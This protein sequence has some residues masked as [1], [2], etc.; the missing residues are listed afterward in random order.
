MA[1]RKLLKNKKRIVIKVGSSTITHKETENLDYGKLEKLVRIITD[2]HNSGKDVVLVTSGAIAVGRHAIGLKDRPDTLSKKQACAAIGQANLM[3]I[4][5]KLFSEYSQLCAQVLL[6]RFT[7]DSDESYTNAE[8]TFNELFKLGV[9]PI[10]NEN[11]TISTAEIKIGDNDSLSAY[12]S[13]MIHADLLILMSDIDGL[14]SADPNKDK[15]AKFISEVEDLDNCT[16]NATDSASSVGTGGMQTKL[17]A[18]AI[19]TKCGA[20]MV[21]TN[22]NDVENIRR[23]LSGENTGTIFTAAYDASFDIRK[24]K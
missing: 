3:N 15:D 7:F 11:D 12:V 5:Q 23:I 19:V 24:E 18:A 13:A 17:H 21:I 1:N 10:V 2:I 22:G 9:V 16:A 6:T 14:Y 4:Y 8:N 20:D